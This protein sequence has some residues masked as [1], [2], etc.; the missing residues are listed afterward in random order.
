MGDA[1]YR[2]Y[3]LGFWFCLGVALGALALGMIHNL[4][5]GR[6]G[7]AI[8]RYLEAATKM[9]PITAVMF[10]PI[11]LMAKNIFPWADPSPEDRIV[12]HKAL[13][14][15]LP[16]FYAR[17]VVYFGIWIWLAR[18]TSREN[19]ANI[20]RAERLSGIGLVIHSFAM[21][22]ASFDWF[23][24]VDPHWF[25]TMFGPLTVVSQI[26]TAFAFLLPRAI[27]REQIEKVAL[28]DL[29]KLFFAFVVLWAYLSFSQ[30]LITWSGNL[31][32]EIPW[33]L[34]RMQGGWE[35]LGVGLIFLHFALP[36]FVLMP[37]STKRNPGRLALVATV[38]L[39]IRFIDVFWTIAPE[40]PR[41]PLAFHFWDFA[42][43]IALGLVFWTMFN[44]KVQTWKS[45]V[46]T[47]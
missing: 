42:I 36:F 25:S 16:F 7:D 17:A 6:W 15:N 37:K 11:A 13:F 8:R 9:I 21:T 3:L 18:V 28:H 19:A 1:F 31:P 10:I 26:L 38:M 27:K 2:G 34:R 20:P 40:F 45:S 33:Y 29:G 12:H 30:F 23:M 46:A 41:G 39:G 22:F 4:T 43:P 44:G 24:S 32:E 35:T 5:G 47:T 14:L